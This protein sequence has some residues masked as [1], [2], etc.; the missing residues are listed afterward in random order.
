MPFLTLDE[1]EAYIGG[2]QASW[3]GDGDDVAETFSW[4]EV[5]SV[6]VNAPHVFLVSIPLFFNGA[7]VCSSCNVRFLTLIDWTSSNLAFWPC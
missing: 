4:S 5:G 3:S 6:F 1:K 2:L 7:T